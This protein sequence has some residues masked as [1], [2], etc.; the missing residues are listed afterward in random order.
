[1]TR[2]MW[3]HWVKFNAVGGMGI[4]VQLMVLTALKSGL[5]IDYLLATALAVEA[6]I[7]P[8]SSGTSAS[9]G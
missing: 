7:V 2:N 4:G 6:A 3:I 1:M 5:H 8:T 9:P